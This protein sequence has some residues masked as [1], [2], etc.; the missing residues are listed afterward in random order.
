MAWPLPPTLAVGL[1]AV[2][3]AVVF[4]LFA[5][6]QRNGTAASRVPL[7]VRTHGMALLDL[8]PSVP[9]PVL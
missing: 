1:V 3:L 5:Q 4:Y 6:K 7:Q 9:W 2:L 8:P